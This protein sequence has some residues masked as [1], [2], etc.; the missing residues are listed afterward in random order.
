MA[1][2]QRGRVR[3]EPSAKRLRAYLGG[4]LVLDT[5]SPLLVWEIPYYPAYYVPA[6]DV[7]AEL[8]DTG[9]TDHSPSRGDAAVLTVR[10]AD[11]EAVGGAL[12]YDD[13]R[14]EALDGHVRFDWDALDAWFEEDEEVFTHPRSP[15]SR[16]DILPTSRE[17][18]V[19]RAGVELA[20]STRAH[21]LFETGLPTRWYVPRVDVRM[22]LLT[23]SETVTHCPYKGRASHFHGRVG[24]TV[25]DDVAWSYP[26]PLPESERV[27]GLVSFYDDRVTV[28]VDGVVQGDG[29]P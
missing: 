5:T 27:A 16:I 25:V 12:R 1:T 2:D 9:K 3:T 15:Y 6:E 22:D 10:T 18:V 7:V 11:H 19:R 14:L 17:V 21:A 13:S 26:T 28:E 20:R 23:P 29:E 24:D 8:V 4:Q